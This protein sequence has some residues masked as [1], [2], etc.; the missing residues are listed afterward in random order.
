MGAVAERQPAVS[1]GVVKEA[2][3]LVVKEA[4]PGRLQLMTAMTTMGASICLTGFVRL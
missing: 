4:Q 1:V 3:A 2:R